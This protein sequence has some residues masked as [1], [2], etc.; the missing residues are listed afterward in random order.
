[1]TKFRLETTKIF[2]R[3]FKKLDK[4]QRKLAFKFI[5]KIA[6]EPESGKSLR[7]SLKNLRRIRFEKFRLIYEIC[8]DRIILHKIEHREKIYE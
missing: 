4:R 8:E 2:D 5:E 3:Q 6:Y 7:Y 1:M